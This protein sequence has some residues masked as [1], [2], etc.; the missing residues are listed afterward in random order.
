MTAGLLQVPG[1]RGQLIARSLTDDPRESFLMG[2][3]LPQSSR[4]LLKVTQRHLISEARES[5]MMSKDILLRRKIHML[6]IM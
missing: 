4:H 6:L 3:G 2:R 1:A 5:F